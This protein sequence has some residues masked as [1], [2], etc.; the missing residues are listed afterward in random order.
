MILLS[1]NEPAILDVKRQAA[2]ECHVRHDMTVSFEERPE[3][4][5]QSNGL[6]KGAVRD[7]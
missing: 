3:Y 4:D 6:A 5:S 1:D 2:M 7:I